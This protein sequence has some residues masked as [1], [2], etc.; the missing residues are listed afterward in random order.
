MT[1]LLLLCQCGLA[2]LALGFIFLYRLR[3]ISFKRF[4]AGL[5]LSLLACFVLGLISLY[6]LFFKEDTG[7]E[8]YISS[9][10]VLILGCMLAALIIKIN[11]LPRIHDIT[12]NIDDPPLFQHAVRQ[13]EVTDNSLAYNPANIHHQQRA[14]PDIQPLYLSDDIDTVFK[15]A[16]DAADVMGWM[17]Y[18]SDNTQ[19]TFEA[20]ELSAL[21]GFADDIIVLVQHSDSGNRIDLRSASRVG[22]SDLGANA[23]RIKRYLAI[24][25]DLSTTG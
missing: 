3:K 2:L 6:A 12:T 14:Y 19:Y 17:V 4:A 23:K 1:A 16:L 11:S 18:H 9:A 13:R 22:V 5:A 20:E 8:V 7:F 24:L 15:W 21:C 25:R 10:V